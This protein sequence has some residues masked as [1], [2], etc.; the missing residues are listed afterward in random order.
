[1][2]R[3][4]CVTA[5]IYDKKGRA[6]SIGRNSYTK[7]HPLMFKNGVKVGR[8]QKIYLHAEVDAILKCRNLKK[9]YKISIFRYDWKGEPVCAKPCPVCMSVITQTP[10]KI[11]EHT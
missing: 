6:L 5:I 1:M 11:I 8:P 3:K 2:R 9:A 4:V 10:I 7:T